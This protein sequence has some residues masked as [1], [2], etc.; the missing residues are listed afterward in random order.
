MITAIN[1]SKSI[2]Y[3]WILFYSGNYIYILYQITAIS[4]LLIIVFL[5]VYLNFSLKHPQFYF[6]INESILRIMLQL[7][8]WIFFLPFFE[9][10]IS[11]FKCT[12]DFHYL[13]YNFTY[14]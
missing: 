11:A 12:N 14:Y 8:Y 9:T 4:Y 1:E 3:Y 5:L 6:E 2:I 7:V 13:V 10:F